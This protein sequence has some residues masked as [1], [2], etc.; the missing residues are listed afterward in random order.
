[1]VNYMKRKLSTHYKYRLSWAHCELLLCSIPSVGEIPMQN[2]CYERVGA[3]LLH[4][5]VL[6]NVEV[7]S[8][9]HHCTVL[10]CL[11]RIV[12]HLFF[13]GNHFDRVM[14]CLWNYGDS[15]R[16]SA[17]VS[18]RFRFRF[19]PF[20]VILMAQ[21]WIIPYTVLNS[22]PYTLKPQHPVHHQ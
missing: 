15:L 6:C 22:F 9:R 10:V 7:Y 16:Q 1:M 2:L 19:K 11:H 21:I 18:S 13:V 14:C 20:Y 17:G 4:R 3:W 12:Q 8:R 5:L